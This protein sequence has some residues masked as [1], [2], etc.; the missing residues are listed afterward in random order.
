MAESLP[1]SLSAFAHRRPRAESVTSFTYYQDEDEPSPGFDRYDERSM[2]DSDEFRFGEDDE[3]SSNLED[4]TAGDDYAL[5]RR[6]SIQS[7][8]S[9][10]A[11]LLRRDSGATVGSSRGSQAARWASAR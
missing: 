1:T 3:S 10:N 2:A 6:P 7:R 9:V 5:H 11:R 4:N 8:S